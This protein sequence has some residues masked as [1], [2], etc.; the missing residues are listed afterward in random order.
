M[1]VVP[2]LHKYR[3]FP[4]DFQEHNLGRV[5]GA[6]ALDTDMGWGRKVTAAP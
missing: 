3:L 4:L 6:L 5:P 2:V 1:E